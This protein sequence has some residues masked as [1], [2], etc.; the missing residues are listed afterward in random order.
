M[1]DLQT[2]DWEAAH[3][4]RWG[5]W[6]GRRVAAASGRMVGRGLSGRGPGLDGLTSAGGAGLRGGGGAPVGGGGASHEAGPGQLFS[7]AEHL[8]SEVSRGCRAE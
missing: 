6:P 4:R 3:F 2:T 7:E 5:A 8:V 1:T